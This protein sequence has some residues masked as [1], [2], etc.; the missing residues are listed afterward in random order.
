[1]TLDIQTNCH[2]CSETL[3][4]NPASKVGKSEECPHCYSDV[5][6]CKMCQF[7]DPKCYNECQ[8]PN[9]ER[10]IEKSK[11]NFCDYFSL[12]A[13]KKQEGAEQDLL[14]AANALFKN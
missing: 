13:N 1:M 7:Y 3:E 9:A 11:S 10:I 6:C 12:S 8:E 5:R 14:S 4:L 2:S